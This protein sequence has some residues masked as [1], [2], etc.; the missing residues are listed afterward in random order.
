MCDGAVDRAASSGDGSRSPN[1]P[2]SLRPFPSRRW[3]RLHAVPVASSRSAPALTRS[4]QHYV[5]MRAC[6]NFGR[7]SAPFLPQC[8]Q[9]KLGSMSESRTVSVGFDV[10]AAAVIAAID[11]HVADAGFA[12]LAEGEL[13]ARQFR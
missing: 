12:H 8:V 13:P 3:R 9:V 5:P 7:T 6:E 1:D 2:I 4:R 11:Q 10:M